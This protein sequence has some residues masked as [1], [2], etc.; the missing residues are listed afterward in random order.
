MPM[1]DPMSPPVPEPFSLE[2]YRVLIFD[3]DGVIKE[4]V[5]VKTDAFA[6]LFVDFGPH[7][8]E[9][10]VAH[11]LANGGM[12]RFDK[13]RIYFR[14]FIGREITDSELAEQC[15]RFARLCRQ[16]VVDSAWVPGALPFLETRSRL[17][18]CYIASGT[19]DDELRWIIDKLGIGTLFQGIYGSPRHKPEI[20]KTIIKRGGHSP[21]EC[22][23]I[24]D[25][26]A[27][28]QAAAKTGCGFLL[29]ETPENRPLFETIDC[30]R[31]RDFTEMP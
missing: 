5:A 12:P 13:I 4:S 30:P 9:R 11:H 1:E 8:Q 31:I 16:A 10:V 20:L 27:D 18:H 22:L 26:L 19:P 23:M 25:A 6:A 15:G 14:D 7:V 24:G 2:P 3:F 17:F 28:H 21:R 29:R